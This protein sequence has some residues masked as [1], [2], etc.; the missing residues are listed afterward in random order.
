[1]IMRAIEHSPTWD[2]LTELLRE[3]SA[4]LDRCDCP[5][6]ISILERAVREYGKPHE[7][8]DLV[9]NYR[10]PAATPEKAKVAV[11]AEHRSQKAPPAAS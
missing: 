3:M 10:Q 4:A 6:I 1:M 7:I 9:W 8:H 11:L 5:A 2:E